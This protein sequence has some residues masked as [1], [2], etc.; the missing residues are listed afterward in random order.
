MN[1]AYISSFAY[2]R[3]VEHSQNQNGEDTNISM[4]PFYKL[5]AI[6]EYIS[7]RAVCSIF[8][9][10]IFNNNSVRAYFKDNEGNII[11]QYEWFLDSHLIENA[12]NNIPDA[13]IF[14]IALACNIEKTGIYSTAFFFNEK[15]IG[16][17]YINISMR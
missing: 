16:E 17:F 13:L 10:N 15:L 4:L 2:C 11:L 8:G 3:N 6:P 14:N 7:L 12:G 9:D 1:T 5:S